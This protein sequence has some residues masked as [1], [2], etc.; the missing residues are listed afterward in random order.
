MR[1]QTSTLLALGELSELLARHRAARLLP[2][3]VAVLEPHVVRDG[4]STEGEPVLPVDTLIW[5]IGLLDQDVEMHTGNGLVELLKIV[6]PFLAGRDTL[7]AVPLGDGSGETL[8]GREQ[9]VLQYIASGYTNG[10]IAAKLNISE[11]TVKSRLRA[12]FRK[13]GVETRAHAVSVAYQLGL[14]TID[15][16]R[17]A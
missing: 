17:A 3:V 4:E 8:T 7:G 13:F 11:D 16:K 5:L 14:L 1:D 12:V 6:R 10:M 15:T 9:I 2:G